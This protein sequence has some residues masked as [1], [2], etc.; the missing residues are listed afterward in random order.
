MLSSRRHRK[1][2]IPNRKQSNREFPIGHHAASPANGR[3]VTTRI[4]PAAM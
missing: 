1:Q 4:I 3:T 2:D